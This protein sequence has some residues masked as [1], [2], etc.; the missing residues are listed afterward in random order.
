MSMA[1]SDADT[2]VY[3]A[4]NP[5]SEGSPELRRETKHVQDAPRILL[6]GGGRDSL[7]IVNRCLQMGLRIIV[8]DIDPAAPARK[9]ADWFLEVD[10]YDHNAVLLEA[11][12][13]DDEYGTVNAVLSAG[14]DTP[15]VMSSISGAWGLSGPSWETATLSKDK[16]AQAQKLLLGGCNVPNT[17][18]TPA[19]HFPI[20]EL[21]GKMVMKPRDSR[22]ARGVVLMKPGDDISAEQYLYSAQFGSGGVILQEWVDGHQISSESL[23][24]DGEILWTA[25]AERNY[26]R[27]DKFAP[28]VIED[29]CDM[30]PLQFRGILRK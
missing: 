6:I 12:A 7:G 13:R 25:Y 9:R 30:P 22:G 5:T 27:L 14:T 24:Q 18:L 17:A 29:G 2:S 16:Y 23:V 20:A 26:D 8:A 19:S 1:I 10:C 21:S 4:E 15:N 11:L 28:Y 3:I